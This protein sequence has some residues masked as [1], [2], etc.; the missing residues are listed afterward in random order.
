MFA[1]GCDCL[2]GADHENSYVFIYDQ[3]VNEVRI[4]G[5]KNR[6]KCPEEIIDISISNGV[7]PDHVE[8]NGNN[9]VF[10]ISGLKK[11]TQMIIQTTKRSYNIILL[12]DDDVGKR[13]IL[14]KE[15]PDNK[16]LKTDYEYLYQKKLNRIYISNK[17]IN[18]FTCDHPDAQ[19][20]NIILPKNSGISKQTDGGNAYLQYKGPQEKTIHI[21]TTTGKNYSV[22]LTPIDT[23]AKTLV[24]KNSNS[25]ESYAKLYNNKREKMVVGVIKSAMTD[26]SSMAEAK[27]NNTDK[28]ITQIGPIK[29]TE[30]SQY[31]FDSDEI[32]LIVYHL[33]TDKKISVDEAYLYN[34]YFKQINREIMGL[35]LD[36]DCLHPNRITR[37]FVV[38]RS[39]SDE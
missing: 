34:S 10:Q 14:A 24:L 35:G 3:V 2:W 31:Q 15:T 20:K 9:A 32:A 19:I 25:T 36:N 26:I 38:I 28:D 18:L 13:T 6:I 1:L 16:K 29:I 17:E 22:C 30:H 39:V 8:V 37:L 27:V 21:V 23:E 12:P 4:S 33:T 7:L 11:N 5:E